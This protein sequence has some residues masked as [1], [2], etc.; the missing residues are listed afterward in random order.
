MI[1]NVKL[2]KTCL[3]TPRWRSAKSALS[4][5]YIF[6]NLH[7]LMKKKCVNSVMKLLPT[8]VGLLGHLNIKAGGLFSWRRLNSSLKIRKVKKIGEKRDNSTYHS[9]KRFFHENIKIQKY[10]LFP[11]KSGNLTHPSKKWWN[12]MIFSEKV[13]IFLHHFLEYYVVFLLLL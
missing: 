7:F 11:R 8:Q 2:T 9:R 10:V 5:G 6:R 3:D 4:P 13:N 1:K 12:N